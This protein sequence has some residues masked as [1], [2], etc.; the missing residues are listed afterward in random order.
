MILTHSNK[1]TDQHKTIRTVLPGMVLAAVFAVTPGGLRAQNG[2]AIMIDVSECIRIVSAIGRFACYEQQTEAVMRSG[3]PVERTQTPPRR[4]PVER[5][6]QS[7]PAQNDDDAVAVQDNG[8]SS[9][10]TFGSR[11]PASSPQVVQ[12]EKG[13]EVLLDTIASLVEREPNR[14]LITLTGGQVWYQANS[15]RFRLREGMQVRIYPSPFG[16]SY[17]LAADEING[18][19]Q[20]NRVE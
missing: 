1:H 6:T 17:R 10:D 18:F 15:K 11:S 3:M 16:S 20:V 8:T 4:A 9:V 12:N 19:I 7:A 5:Q 13:D 14:W 2:D